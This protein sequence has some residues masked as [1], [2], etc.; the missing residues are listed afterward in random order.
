MEIINY[1]SGNEGQDAHNKRRR[2]RQR[3]GGRARME[4]LDEEEP[5]EAAE[6]VAEKQDV[7]SSR[8]GRSYTF[9]IKARDVLK[10]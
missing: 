7:T 2:T 10:C 1:T 5:G 4:I 8:V 3:R 9:T 6:E